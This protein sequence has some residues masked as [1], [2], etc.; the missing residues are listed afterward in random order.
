MTR[1]SAIVVSLVAALAACWASRA[2]AE[3]AFMRLTPLPA[4]KVI[5]AA[6]AFPGGAYSAA[7]LLDGEENSEY[8]SDGKGT[9]TFVEFDFGAPVIIGAFRHVDRHDLAN[10]ATSQLTFSDAAGHP[11][12]T[13][14][15]PH[16]GQSSGVTMFALPKPV[17]AQKVRWQVTKVAHQGIDCVGGREISFFKAGPPE[18]APHGIRIAVQTVPVA[19]QQDGRLVQSLRVALEYPYAAPIDATLHVAGQDAKPIRLTF[20]SQSLVYSAPA[21]TAAQPMKVAIEYAGQTVAARTV[22][23]KPSRKMTVYLLPHSH[24]DI[25]YTHLQTDVIRRQCDNIDKALEL[26]AKTAAYPPEARFK[27]NAEVLWAIDSYLRNAP[28]EK[29]QRLVEA[30]R[31]GQVELDGLYGNELTGLCRPEELLRLMQWGITLGRRC[32]VKVESAMISDVP[33]LTWGTVAS[34]AQAGVKY[35]SLGINFIDGGRTTSAWEDKPFYWLGPDGRQKILCWLPTKGYQMGHVH[36]HDLEKA[37]AEHLMELE[38]KG[39]AYDMVYFRWNVGGDNGPP[40]P[41]ISDLVKNWNAKHAYPKMVIA[42]TTELFRAFEKRYAK[43]IPVV[44]GDFTPYWE[45]GAASSAQETAINRTA[46]ERLV[47]AEALSAM[48]NPRHYPAEQFTEAWRNVI[49]Y[50][51]HTWGAYN[52]ITDPDLPFVKEQWKIKQAF[53]LDA[54]AESQKLLA[55][56]LAEHGGD[57]QTGSVDVWNTSGWPRTDLVVLSKAMAPPATASPGPTVM[58]FPRSGFRRANW[59]SWPKKCPPWPAD[60]TQSARRPRCPL[61]RP[62]PKRTASARRPFRPRWIRSPVRW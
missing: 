36:P 42:T 40:D 49:L 27:W 44:S 39:Y 28:P 15:V 54:G 1:K 21:L 62:R 18:P 48:L 52:S 38:K 17:T 9:N 22:E 51:E 8:A 33:G 12:A 2:G 10:V 45:N 32:G 43:K 6:K 53:A 37:M 13:V 46:A 41:K 30:I 5:A 26:I 19:E 25:G 55:D 20:G 11:L 4:P 59:P 23:L 35:F 47:Q 50:D 31:A 7:F 14:S 61:A 58:P 24:I 56:A 57:Q 3:G 29:Q 34:C 16:V 60:D